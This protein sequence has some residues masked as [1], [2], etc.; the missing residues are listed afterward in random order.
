[1]SPSFPIA[2]CRHKAPYY[3]KKLLKETL[4]SPNHLDLN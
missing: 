1:M 3:K 4:P 2:D